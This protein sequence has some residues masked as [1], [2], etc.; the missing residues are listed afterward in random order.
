VKSLEQKLRFFVNHLR[1][2]YFSLTTKAL[3]AD[4]Q[5]ALQK[6]EDEIPVII[7]SYN[8][9]SYVKNMTDQLNAYRIKPIVIDNRSTD[10]ASVQ[11]LQ[12]LHSDQKAE[13]V[14]SQKNYGYLVGF[15]NPIYA[16]LPQY[17]AYSDPD[18]MLNEKLPKDFLQTM[19]LLTDDYKVFKAGF[20]LEI[21]EGL[22][23]ATITKYIGYPKMIARTYDFR[24]WE[25]QY[26]RFELKHPTLKIY[27]SRVDTTFAVY[28]KAN[29][30][31][32]FYDGIRVGG[33]FSAIHLPWYP[34]L[35]IMTKQER[36][37]YLK[38][39]NSTTSIPD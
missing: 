32:E 5:R 28:N 23:S 11:I 1:N 20:A 7:V 31:D 24:E 27:A 16:L 25:E 2:R 18:L 35:D 22:Q 6:C 30:F 12:Q 29:Y 21:R 38:K 33:D 37:I 17:F 14:F 3:Q 36:N 15:I 4:L 9:A 39:N 26:W 19:K 34:E 13:V 10:A 8:N